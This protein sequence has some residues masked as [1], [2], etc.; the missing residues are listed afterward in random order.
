ME[1]SSR[2]ARARR[3]APAAGLVLALAFG[4]A[5]LASLGGCA[6]V[7]VTGAVVGTAVSVAGTAVST[8]VSVAG[9]A[10]RTTGK[11]VGKTVDVLTPSAA[12]APE[13]IPR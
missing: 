11:V 8:T 3:A 7:A 5:A 9:T 13:T 12:P 1:S 6:V 4:L 10:V 2:D